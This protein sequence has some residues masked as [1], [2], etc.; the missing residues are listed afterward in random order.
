MIYMVDI[1][2]L[3]D[4]CWANL[5][6]LLFCCSLCF[7][8]NNRLNP[9]NRVHSS[10]DVQAVMVHF[11]IIGTPPQGEERDIKDRMGQRNRQTNLGDGRVK[12]ET[13]SKDREGWMSR[14]TKRD[15]A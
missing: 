9:L 12:W 7:G 15:E 13:L 1:W 3:E 10:A 6:C 14:E 2:L 4:S 5:L 8:E 11:I